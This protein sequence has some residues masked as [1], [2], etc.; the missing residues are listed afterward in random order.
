MAGYV[1]R[2]TKRIEQFHKRERALLGA[3]KRGEKLDKLCEEAAALRKAKLSAIKSATA[4]R[5]PGISV[6]SGADREWTT[7]SVE[8]IINLYRKQVHE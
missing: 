4:N 5:R 1:P 8:E 2:Y 6:P 7:M 3:L